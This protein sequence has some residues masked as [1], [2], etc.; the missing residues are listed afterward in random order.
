MNNKIYYCERERY[1]RKKFESY[2]LDTKVFRKRER[3][4]KSKTGSSGRRKE[5][6]E[7]D[8]QVLQTLTSPNTKILKMF[9]GGWFWGG[10][11]VLLFQ[12]AD[13]Q[14]PTEIVENCLLL[15]LGLYF[16]LL[17]LNFLST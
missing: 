16:P 7:F 8:F 14:N 2:M 9:S 10:V 13:Y 12:F 3:L 6:K 17:L 1:Y 5:R 11:G 4:G 15:S